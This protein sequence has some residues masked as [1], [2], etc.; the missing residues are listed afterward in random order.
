M[1]DPYKVLGVDKNADEKVIKD[2]YR[3]L[4]KQHHPDTNGGD[5]S[6]F[7]EINDAYEILSDPQKRKMFDSTGSTD[8]RAGGFGGGGSFGGFEDIFS[9]F[10]GGG[11]GSFGGFGDIF[12]DIFGGMGRQGG[13][14]KS[15]AKTVT[16]DISFKES[17]LGASKTIKF[18]RKNKCTVC[19][20]TGAEDSSD[21]KTCS[22]C[23]G[24]GTVMKQQN[25][26]FGMAMSTAT[27]PDCKGS[28]KIIKNPCQECSGRG[29]V[30]GEHTTKINVP[31]NVDTGDTLLV[32]GAGDWQN[33]SY[34]ELHVAIRTKEDKRFEKMANGDIFTTIKVPIFSALLGDKI[35]I[36]TIDGKHE[37]T[38][39]E[40]TK[41]GTRLRMASHGCKIGDSR[42]AMIMEVAYVYP[43]KLTDKVKNTLKEIK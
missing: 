42:R 14:K 25:T 22:T 31:G 1:K 24:Q 3:K 20:G 8:P 26:M 6:K 2:S 11:G 5:D 39:P 19:D 34:G 33:G 21:V 23:G 17:C 32:N 7:K 40:L 37:L 9:S 28:G 41:E 35:S 15:Q 16:L 38:L 43:N 13:R 29:T 4:A 36:D 18:K 10:G 12:G 27:C 30:D